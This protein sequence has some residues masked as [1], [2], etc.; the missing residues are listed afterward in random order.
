MNLRKV[1]KQ[2]RRFIESSNILG[3]VIDSLAKVTIRIAGKRFIQ[4]SEAFATLF[5]GG[6]SSQRELVVLAERHST[7]KDSLTHQIKFE[8]QTHSY[9]KFYDLIFSPIKFKAKNIFE[10]GI[11][12]TSPDF[13]SNMGLSGAPGASLRMWRD[14]FVNADIYGADI[15]PAVLFEEE[16][17]KTYHLDQ[18]S[19][20]S[21]EIM[22]D[23]IGALEFDVMIDDG[24]HSPLGG[25][26]LLE[27][28][29]HKLSR[30]GIYII[31][32]VSIRHFQSYKK[33]LNELP[34]V[35]DLIVLGRRSES[36]LDNNLLVIRKG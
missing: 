7:D 6:K 23:Q 20:T 18:T 33:R 19:K 30:D 4:E 12:T 8:W 15:D 24:L 31:E 26:R 17:I 9:C 28:S 32:D 16:R 35:Y 13:P 2:I 5:F 21:I 29:L 14:Y 34:I 1:N 25:I 36:S 11:G 10:C 3:K 22:W 27:N